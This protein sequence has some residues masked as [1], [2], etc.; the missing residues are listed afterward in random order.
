[1]M[2]D[3]VLKETVMQHLIEQFGNVEAERFISLIIKEPFD[4]T[5]WQGSLFEGMS[6]DD[7]FS[8]L[9]KMERGQA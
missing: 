2:T 8:N 1:M 9:E 3:T 7:I 5:E 6:V 4:Y